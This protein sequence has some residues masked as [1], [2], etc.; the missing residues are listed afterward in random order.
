[1][2]SEDFYLTLLQLKESGWFNYVKGVIVGRV[3]FPNSY[4]TMTYQNALKKVFGSIPLIFN[5]DIGHVPPKMTL[6]NGCIANISFYNDKGII[7]QYLK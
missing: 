5:A 2:T 4:T 1:M 3:L 7:K 6:I